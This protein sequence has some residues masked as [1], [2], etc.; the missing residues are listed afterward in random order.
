[1]LLMQ[2]RYRYKVRQRKT[3]ATIDCCGIALL[4]ALDSVGLTRAEVDLLECWTMPVI[5]AKPRRVWHY[6]G[7]KCVSD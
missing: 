4:P 5:V 2:A 7:G 1:M 3:G 6:E